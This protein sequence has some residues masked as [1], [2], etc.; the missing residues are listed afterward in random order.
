M[1]QA[2][3]SRVPQGTPKAVHR[4]VPLVAKVVAALAF[5]SCSKQNSITPNPAPARVGNRIQDLKQQIAKQEIESAKA[6][7]NYVPAR[8]TRIDDLKS[9]VVDLLRQLPG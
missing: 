7:A 1:L 5:S 8:N 3:F 4:A 2:N 9:S 6:V